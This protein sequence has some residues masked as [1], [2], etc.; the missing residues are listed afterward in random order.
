MGNT[1]TAAIV[2][3]NLNKTYGKK[4]GVK[5]LNLQVNQGEIFGFIGPNGAGKSTTIRMLLQLIAP[6]SGELTVLGQKIEGDNPDLRRRMGYLPSEIS[7]YPDMTGMQILEMAAGVRGVNL[8]KSF[9][10]EYISRLHLDTKSRF[11]SYSLGNRKKLG[12]LLT[13]LHEPELLILDEP[14]S[15]LDPLVQL[16]FFEILREINQR[17]GTTIF[18]STHVLTEVE[19]ICDRVAIIRDGEMIRVSPVSDLTTD[20][21][22]FFEFTCT[23]PG[24]LRQEYGL[25]SID[26]NTEYTEGVYRLRARDDK[27]LALIKILGNKPIK[28]LNVRRLTL[29]ERFMDEY[30]L[31]KQIRVEEGADEKIN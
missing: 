14:T 5:N 9:I 17:R 20:G 8:G 4:R 30:K 13:L 7:L 28:D 11:K 25:F 19:K 2:L 26:P 16:H 27:F 10:P 23:S 29:E 21:D 18:F 31:E 24:D 12:I 6:T 22:H 15:G 3:N 1:N